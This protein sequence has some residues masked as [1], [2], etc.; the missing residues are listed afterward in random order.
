MQRFLGILVVLLVLAGGAGY[1]TLT[2]R[3][4]SRLATQEK[5]AQDKV[6][7]VE[8]SGRTAAQQ[9]AE[10]LTRVLATTISGDLSRG[11]YGSLQ[12]ELD[13]VVRGNR[14]VRIIVLDAGGRVVATTD[15]RYAGQGP[16]EEGNRRAAAVQGVTVESGVLAPGELEVDAPVAV[17]S[18]QVGAVRVFVN[19]AP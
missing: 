7:A 16:E 17:G 6:Q 5:A 2:Y 13:A 15:R 14:V 18:Q 3:E 8:E 10:D 9:L 12:S 19:I 4:R 11:E 1:L